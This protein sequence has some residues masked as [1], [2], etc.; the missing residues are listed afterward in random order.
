MNSERAT[1]PGLCAFLMLCTVA[2][3][4]AAPNLRVDVD[5][6]DAARRLAHA[7]VRVDIPEERRGKPVELLYV[8]WTPGNHNPSGPIQNVID[9]VV[10]DATGAR[11]SWRRDEIDPNRHIVAGGAGD[12]VVAEFSYITNQ[13]AVNSRSS[14]TYGFPN[15]GG[16]NW[17]TLLVYPDWSTKEEI[18]VSATIT[19]PAGWTW[20][21]GLR[22]EGEERL[23]DGATLVRF[24]EASLREVVDSP[25]I[26]GEH[27]RTYELGQA[28]G[29]EHYLH[30]VAAN[31]SRTELA[32]ERLEALRRMLAETVAVFG[33]APMDRYHFLVLLDDALP[34][35]GLEH[36]TSTFI[37]MGSERFRK[38]GAEK[39]PLTVLPH[40][41]IHAWCGKWAAPQG[42]LTED[43]ASSARTPLLWVYEGLTS[44]YDEIVAVRSGLQSSEKFVDGLARLL[45]SYER[46]AG[47]GWRS[48]EDTAIAMRFLRARSDMWE[49]RRRRQDYYGEGSVFWL[50]ADAIIRRGTDG[51]RSLDDVCRALFGVREGEQIGSTGVAREYTREDIVRALTEAYDVE[52]WDGLIRRMIEEPQTDRTPFAA[53]GLLGA[54]LVWSTEAND[55]QKKSVMSGGGVDVLL[56]MGLRTDKEGVVTG[57]RTGSASELADVRVGDRV[58]GVRGS[59]EGE[60]YR[61]WG[62]EALREAVERTPETGGITL[63]VARGENLLE[64]R[65]AYGEGLVFPGLERSEGPH[66]LLGALMAPRAG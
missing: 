25:V 39:D 38:A 47:R 65:V 1:R 66:D 23:E 9:F 22:V 36:L 21:S 50:T 60:G 5:V 40:E 45:G 31:A 4:N 6:R 52:D 32:D 34:G 30:A 43:Y 8:E 62:S 3:A 11:A 53:P 29:A 48:V 57:V 2:C 61:T 56:T 42:L 13:P 27:L 26:Y 58:V 10:W 19:L 41:Y 14:D 63:L 18:K 44:Y 7:R 35:F 17:N 28:G 12:H 24:A 64:R 54:P 37:S 51:A 46:Q 55:D 59:L 33:S 15:F 20:A 16:L 49:D